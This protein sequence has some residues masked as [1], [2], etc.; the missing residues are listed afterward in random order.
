MY[1]TN[2]LGCKVVEQAENGTVYI[3]NGFEH[4]HIVVHPSQNSF[5]EG[6]GWQVHSQL[7]L[8]DAQYLLREEGIVSELIHE[9]QPGVVEQLEL[10]DPDG[11]RIFL[12][13][14]MEYSSPGY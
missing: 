10:K 7:E 9:K 12:Y 4:H 13:H 1:Y 5:M 6:I 11:N 3:S 2:I 14:E 8:K